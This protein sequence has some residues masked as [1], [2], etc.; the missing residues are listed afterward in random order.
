M[1]REDWLN[2]G[3]AALQKT[4]FKPNDL[5]FA[6]PLKV[7]VGW[8]RGSNKAIGQCWSSNASLSGFVE[9]FISPQLADPVRVLDVLLHE[10]IHAHLGNGKGHGK[11]FKKLKEQFGLAGRVTATIAEVG[12]D[13]YNQ[14]NA[15]AQSLGE[16]PH[17]A[18]CPSTE[19]EGKKEEPKQAPW[20]R[21][22]SKTMDSYR[23]MVSPKSL[24]EFGIPKDPNGEELI[25]T[26]GD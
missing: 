9:I 25:P 15:M 22:K 7:S 21:F 1:N 26:K 13:L 11:E 8:C 10:M 23:V 2:A 12:S 6:H 19:K 18:I 17:S 4:F 24:E 5:E 3:V 20:V 14:L 16:F